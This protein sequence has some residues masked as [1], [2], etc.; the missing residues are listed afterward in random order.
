MLEDVVAQRPTEVELI[1]GA[2][3]R[4]A[5]RHGV[6]VP[7]HEALYSLLKGKEASWEDAEIPIPSIVTGGPDET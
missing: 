5:D 6:A 4:E 7:L 1:T 2:L 3:V